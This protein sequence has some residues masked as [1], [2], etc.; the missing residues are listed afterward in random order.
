MGRERNNVGHQ[1]KLS[2]DSILE[3]PNFQIQLNRYPKID[4]LVRERARGSKLGSV[5]SGPGRI[6]NGSIL[7]LQPTGNTCPHLLS[8]RDVAHAPANIPSSIVHASADTQETNREATN[9][10]EGAKSSEPIKFAEHTANKRQWTKRETIQE[11]CCSE[12]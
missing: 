11:P 5:F 2:T 12:S 3:D 1:Q 6:F 7:S 4:N 8:K 10:R 9:Q